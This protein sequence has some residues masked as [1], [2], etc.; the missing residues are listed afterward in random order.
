MAFV[1]SARFTGHRGAVYALAEGYG[2]GTFLSGSGDGRVV[3]WRLDDPG[4]GIVLASVPRA[5]FS[6]LRAKQ[7]QLYIGDE[8]GGLHMVDPAQRQEL[9]LERA[10]VKGIFSIAELPHGRIAAAGGDGYLSVWT[11]DAGH[12]GKIALQ[13]KIP[14]SDDKL[15]GLALSPNGE[16]LAIACGDGSIHVLDSAALNERAT[17]AGHAIGANSVAWHPEKPLLVSG[18]KDGQL[19]FWRTDKEFRPMHAFAAHKDTIYAI[20]FSPDG[21]LLASAARDKTVKLWDAADFAP[22]G[23]LDRSAGGHGYS[24]NALLWMENHRLLSASDDK[25]IVVWERATGQSSPV[26][27]GYRA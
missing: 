9:Q 22:L 3:R 11:V 18:G 8:D 23:R 10:H 25:N 1:P 5:I 12:G 14:L 27:A 7:G 4:K 24:V 2:P 19:R 13:R 17:I 21:R 20:A 16:L 26:A 6:L 15:R